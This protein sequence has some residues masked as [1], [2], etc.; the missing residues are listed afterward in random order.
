[1]SS[2]MMIVCKEDESTYD[3]AYPELAIF[4]DECGM[5]EPFSDFG[6][7][8]QARYCGMPSIIE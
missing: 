4:V 3:G 7:W 8:F 5:G 1:M 6:K 2:D